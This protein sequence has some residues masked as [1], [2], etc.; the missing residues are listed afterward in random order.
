MNNTSDHQSLQQEY[1][2]LLFYVMVDKAA[3][4]RYIDA[5]QV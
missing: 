3:I 4:I 1:A 2:T 5:K